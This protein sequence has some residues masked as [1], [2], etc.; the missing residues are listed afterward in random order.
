MTT[1]TKPEF[2]VKW[3]N[4][5][6]SPAIRAE[7]VPRPL[8]G[9]LIQTKTSHA[10]TLAMNSFAMLKL[11]RNQPLWLRTDT[12]IGSASAPTAAPAGPKVTERP[13]WMN[14]VGTQETFAGGADLIAKTAIRKIVVPATVKVV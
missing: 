12:P 3:T 6:A 10:A 2:T 14:A 11:V 9:P 8:P 1:A 4:P 7:P 5:A 13:R